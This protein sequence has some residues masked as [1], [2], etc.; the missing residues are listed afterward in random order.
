MKAIVNGYLVFP[1]EIRK[2]TLLLD[3]GTAF[4]TRDGYSS[5]YNVFG[6][7]EGTGS[8]S[9]TGKPKQGYVF[10]VATN[11]YGSME[12]AA[13]LNGSVMEGRRVVFGEIS[14]AS[15]LPSQSAT[16]TVKAG[17]EASI[18]SN[19]TWNAHHGVEVAGTLIVKGAWSTLD[20][21][22]G[23]AMGLELADG[24]TLR[25]DA[26]D[27]KLT[28]AKAPHLAAGAT[29]H[30]AFAAGVSPHAGMVLAAW[31]EGAAPAG[32][33][34]FADA[35]VSKDWALSKTATGLVVKRAPLPDNV[36]ARI[37]VRHW[38]G[39]AYV[40]EALPFDLPTGWVTNYFP[41]LDS[42]DAVAAK[43]G[44]TA[45]NGAAVWQCYM[46]GLDPTNAESR[47]SLAMTVV[48][49]KLRFAVE[50][51]G[52]T[53]EIAGISVSWSLKTS[54][55]LASDP[56]FSNSREYKTGLPPIFDEHPIPDVPK[57][58]AQTVDT[59]FYKV[60]ATFVADD[61]GN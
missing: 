25:F 35:E 45:A 61:G 41:S 17:A 22:D 14:E 37:T 54:T 31:P 19:A 59:L 42:R 27:A 9:F 53:H 50:G 28:F 4:C 44:E 52:E 8:M 40:D 43:Y 2:G 56:G 57:M 33:F 24:S 39:S 18:G 10:N 47:V 6:A 48:G 58:G 46:L 5:T 3:G 7:L 21:N 26:A 49:G 38:N 51:L 23:A 30:V 13:A 15:G 29:S 60:T 11:F 12:V 36:S 1:E 32:E 34:A 55:D 16:I 20:C